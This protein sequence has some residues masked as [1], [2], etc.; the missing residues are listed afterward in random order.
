MLRAVERL[1]FA[2]VEMQVEWRR[3]ARFND[4]LTVTAELAGCGGASINFK[5]AVLRGAEPLLAATVRVAAI[6]ADTLRP[7]R[8]PQGFDR[9]FA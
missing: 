7:R 8:L 2:V 9:K 5:Q 1:Q 4:L 3:A 6:D